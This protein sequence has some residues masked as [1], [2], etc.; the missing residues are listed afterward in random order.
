MTSP[1]FYKIL[2]LVEQND[3]TA[4]NQG[5]APTHT[6]TGEKSERTKNSQIKKKKKKIEFQWTPVSAVNIFQFVY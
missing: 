2:F 5:H 4:Q 3:G 1:I 6:H